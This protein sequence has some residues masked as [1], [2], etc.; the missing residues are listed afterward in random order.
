MVR[1]SAMV[2]CCFARCIAVRR[3]GMAIA[4]RI[5]IIEIATR[6]TMTTTAMINAAFVPPLT[7]GRG[8]PFVGLPHDGHGLYETVSTDAPQYAQNAIFDDWTGGILSPWP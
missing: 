3:F 6:P 1:M 4:A 5:P 8:A 7:T 2:R